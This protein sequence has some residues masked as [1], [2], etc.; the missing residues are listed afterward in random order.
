[1]FS[2]DFSIPTITLL[3]VVFVAVMFLLTVY[4]RRVASVAR[5]AAEC[6][7]A[8]EASGLPRVSV[9]VYADVDVE[10]SCLRNML[11]QVLG[12]EYPAGYEVIVINDGSNSVTRQVV[13]GLEALHPNL[14][15]SFTPDD[16]RNLSRRKLALTIGIK[17]ARSE[18]V[19]LTCG[20]A[21]IDSSR[22]LASMARHFAEGK[23]VVIGYASPD[24]KADREV[25]CR[26][27]AFANAAEAV[28]Y[29]SSAIGGRAYRGTGY[30]MAYRREVFFDNK[31]F[32]RSLNLQYGD[33]DLFVDEVARRYATVVELSKDS[34]VTVVTDSPRRYY[35]EMRRRYAFTY[36]FIKGAPRMTLGMCSLMM[37]V[38]LAASCGAVASAWGN[39]PVAGAVLLLG[40]ALWVPVLMA[41]RRT[42]RVLCSRRLLLTLPMMILVR[43]FVNVAYRLRARRRD[44]RN[45]TWQ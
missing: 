8:A 13:E 16:M 30:N 17:A 11:E 19:V 41:W 4:R 43:P 24:V 20:D 34:H 45:Y 39:L 38:W 28:D 29:L 25:G 32:S 12:Q 22:W 7:S 21:R 6:S 3:S 40:V 15:L 33:D 31:G 14:Y 26:G 10:T 36:R 27:R 23:D 42:L 37:W 35:R 9:V 5:R 44:S 1:M 18:V 2:L